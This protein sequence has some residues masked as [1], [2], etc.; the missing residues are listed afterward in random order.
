MSSVV[1]PAAPPPRYRSRLL[2]GYA[3][4]RSAADVIALPRLGRCLVPWMQWI[5]RIRR[6]S[7]LLPTMVSV[8]LEF[9]TPFPLHQRSQGVL[10]LL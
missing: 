10:A 5:S 4:A 2:S 6:L 7:C 3:D 8:D 1:T 9:P